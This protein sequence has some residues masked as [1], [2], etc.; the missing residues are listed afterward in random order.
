MRTWSIG[1]VA[2]R[3]GVSAS[4]IRFYESIGVLPAPARVS[5]RRRYT[6]QVL[7][8]LAAVDLAQRAGF[9]LDEIRDLGGGASGRWR[10]LAAEKLPEIEEQIREALERK[11]LLLAGMECRC[12]GLE[13]CSL[14]GH[15]TP[16]REV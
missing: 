5:G 14:L 12:A 13:D 2:R 7:R 1:E 3:S 6:P 15:P 8:R 10:Q 16:D 9:R 4:A 11:R